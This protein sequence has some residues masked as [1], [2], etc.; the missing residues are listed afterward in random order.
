VS[1]VSRHQLG[2]VLV[3]ATVAAV[4]IF[5]SWPG[6][7]TGAGTAGGTNHPGSSTPA[8]SIPG[9]AGIGLSATPPTSAAPATATPT[10]PARPLLTGR[11]PGSTTAGVRNGSSVAAWTGGTAGVDATS[12]RTYDHVSVPAPA[13]GPWTFTGNNITFRDC[14]FTVGVV[15][16]GNHILL[17]HCDIAGGITIRGN[18][19]V[20][21]VGNDIHGWDTGILVD[22]DPRKVTDVSIMDNWVHAPRAACD[23]HADGVRLLGVD[24]IT[25]RNNT[26]DLGP[27]IPCGPLGSAISVEP[28]H[29]PDVN[30][31]ITN[32]LLNGGAYTVR[33]VACSKTTFEANH[34]G[35]DA[36]TAA[37]NAPA[38]PACFAH[39]Q[40]NVA[41]AT[42][43]PVNPSS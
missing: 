34:F 43:K 27:W 8:G 39:W 3:L 40:G 20:T 38:Y 10:P 11:W 25:M 1:Q 14:R 28:T 29:G 21:L 33:F 2:L 4:L 37:A 5:A 41:D 15:F 22:G 7:A 42:G 35:P 18:A 17:D 32:N 13:S 19:A 36:H 9:Q 30:M 16:T 31:T 6:G 24:G 23:S 12:G 26:V